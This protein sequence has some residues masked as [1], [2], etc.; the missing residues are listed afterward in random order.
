MT[1]MRK[2]FFNG[3]KFYQFGIKKQD[4]PKEKWEDVWNRFSLNSLSQEQDVFGEI[5]LK[6][7]KKSQAPWD[8]N[9]LEKFAWAYEWYYNKNEAFKEIAE[10]IQEETGDASLENAY[11]F[12]AKEVFGEEQASS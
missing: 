12:M 5:L 3:N 1:E 4:I 10:R 9:P 8:K 7:P 11:E 2:T 6:M